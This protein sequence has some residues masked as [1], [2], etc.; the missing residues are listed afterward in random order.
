MKLTRSLW[1]IVSFQFQQ[2]PLY[3]SLFTT[4]M[5]ERGLDS[6]EC[7]ISCLPP[8]LLA[9]IFILAQAESNQHPFPYNIRFEVLLSHVSRFCRAVSLTI[10][11]FWNQIDIYTPHSLHRV[12]SYLERSGPQ[13]L[14]DIYINLSNWERHHTAKRLS[15][16]PPAFIQSVADYIIS[17]LHRIRSLFSTCFRESTCLEILHILRNASAPNLRQLQVNSDR[18]LHGQ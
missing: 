7:K 8:E 15:K 17:H 6:E 9:P 4:T 10:R 18:T 2:I 5:D 1:S 12:S 11:R 13:S 14:L 3:T 16:S